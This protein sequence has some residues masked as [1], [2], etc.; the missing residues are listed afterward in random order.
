[1]THEMNEHAPDEIHLPDRLSFQPTVELIYRLSQFERGT[2]LGWGATP[3][4][5]Y[6][7]SI[8]KQQLGVQRHVAKLFA[9][10]PSYI[11]QELGRYMENNNMSRLHHRLDKNYK[12]FCHRRQ[13]DLTET[14]D[15]LLDTQERALTGNAS[16][17]EVIVAATQLGVPTYELSSITLA[18]GQQI[19]ELLAPSREQVVK[20]VQFVGGVIHPDPEVTYQVKGYSK[21]DAPVNEG[22]TES[23][24]RITRTKKVASLDKVTDVFERSSFCL[25]L[26]DYLG[27]IVNGIEYGKTATWREQILLADGVK[28]HISHLLES[29]QFNKAVPSSITTYVVNHEL[30]A[31]LI[32]DD[33][34][35]RARARQITLEALPVEGKTQ[36]PTPELDKL[37]ELHQESNR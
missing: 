25:V 28:E 26:D 30:E 29:D 21:I 6:Y 8:R 24:L 23:V 18:Y 35:F 3:L 5:P 36:V 32:D 9:N 16:P 20:A 17:A 12:S 27:N 34:A 15:I 7:P 11:S 14:P 31:L 37:R 1:M 4:D 10:R 2:P 33:K 22:G 13:F 19:D